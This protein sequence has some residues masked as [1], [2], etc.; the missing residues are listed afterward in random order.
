MRIK[1]IILT[2]LLSPLMLLAEQKPNILFCIADD[3]ALDFGVYGCEWVKTP[4]FDRIANEG[5]LF[6]RAYT[7]NA[8]CAPSRAI[9]LTGRY[10]WQLEEAGNHM[11]VFPA[12]FKGYFEALLDNGYQTGYTG[13]G[14]GPGTTPG[15]KITGK[16]YSKRKADAPTSKISRTDYSANFKD[17]MDDIDN[18]KPWCFWFGTSEPHRGFE[19]MSG[20]KKNG[21][22]L[23]DIPQVPAYWPDTETVRHDMLDYGFEVEHFDKHL[24]QIVDTLEKRGELENTLIV[25]TSDHGR[26]FPRMKGQCYE[27]SN[28]I[29][30]AVMWKGQINGGHIID[31]YINFTDLVPTFLEAAQVSLEE[32]GMQPVSGKSLIPIFKANKSGQVESWRD[33]VVI[34]KERHDVG[35]P[36]NWGY[37]TRGIIKDGM[38]FLQNFETDRW[39][40]GNPETGY[41]NCDGGA[42][43]TEILNMRREGKSDKYWQLC[44]GKRPELEL[45][46]L[47]KDP[48]CVNNLANNPEYAQKMKQLKEELFKKL[49]EQGDP[50]MAGKGE[51]FDNY[52][53]FKPEFIDFY[54]KFTS[55][56]APKTGW[57][58]PSDFEKEPIKNTK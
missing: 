23:S 54:K 10:S 45:Y 52:E 14:W 50:R 3:A 22:K 26:P 42:T 8:K 7:P 4:A 19:F 55:G 46:Q 27:D 21:K 53:V 32:S 11:P 41:L 2:V 29:P 51:V 13:K 31:D 40:S 20:V 39:P 44:F 12:K 36:N 57:V 49:T 25:V 56:K 28:H 35:R 38:L 33:H 34:G 47:N 1:T 6:N 24:G 15:R 48:N 16:N 9:I 58:N 30:F 43:K 37:P 18:S 5:L 17:F